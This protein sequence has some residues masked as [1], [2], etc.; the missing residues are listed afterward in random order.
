MFLLCCEILHPVLDK[1][2][3]HRLNK[4]LIAN[5]IAYGVT[6]FHMCRVSSAVICW[7]K[8]IVWSLDHQTSRSVLVT[9]IKM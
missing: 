6:Y 1:G 2:S 9:G 3:K 7:E 8:E 4:A 5:V